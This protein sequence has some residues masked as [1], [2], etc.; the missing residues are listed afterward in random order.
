[1]VKLHHKAVAAV[2]ARPEILLSP[3]M[4]C[5]CSVGVLHSVVQDYY[6]VQYKKELCSAVY[7]SSAL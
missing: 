5:R 4:Q 1:M 2:T 3:T 7:T 6:T